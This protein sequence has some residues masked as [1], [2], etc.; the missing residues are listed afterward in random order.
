MHEDEFS[1]YLSDTLVRNVSNLHCLSIFSNKLSANDCLTT[2]KLSSYL[3]KTKLEKRLCLL[4][5]G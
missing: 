5:L 3:Q 4:K 1:L 2:L